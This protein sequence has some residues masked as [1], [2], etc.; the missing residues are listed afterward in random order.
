MSF[1]TVLL[2]LAA[3]FLAACGPPDAVAVRSPGVEEDRLE[4]PDLEAPKADKG[5]AAPEDP[6]PGFSV[7][8]FTGDRFSL[9]EQRGTPVVLNFWESW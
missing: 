4:V 6:A 9:G 2:L 7:T 5:S 8:T 1:R 3:I